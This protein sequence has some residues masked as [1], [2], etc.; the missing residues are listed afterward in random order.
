[1]VKPNNATSSEQEW[2]IQVQHQLP[3]SMVL[4]VGYVGAAG[5]HLIDKYNL[6]EQLF[7]RPAGVH[8]YPGL[9]SVDVQDARG[10]S[11]YHALQTE[12]SRR[13]SNGLQ[14]TAAYTFSKTIDDGAGTNGVTGEQIF[15][16]IRLDRS[17]ADIDLRNRFVLSGVY[18]LPFGRGKK[19]GG[20]ISKAANTLVGGW[21]LNTIIT[22]QSGIPFSLTT[23]GQPSSG[24]PTDGRPDL[25]G[26]LT[27]NP[28]NTYQY[29]NIKAV[30]QAPQNGDGVLLRQ[31]TLGRN[32]LIGP[33]A[34]TVDL[35]MF[36]N[37]ALT[38]RFKLEFRAEAFNIA[39]HPVYKQPNTDITAGNFGQITDTQIGSERQL[40]G[41]L[42]LFF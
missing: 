23:P 4:S 3:Y 5:H 2:N 15:Q 40:Q 17:L 37:F 14:F 18:E 32:V 33:G 11:I 26:N 19:F 6:N 20:N 28:G 12:L 31:G 13:F 7:N 21:Q 10:N 38:E 25:V 34:R 24:S 9:G 22:I 8:L 16:S 29:F 41:V 36:K 35:S 30:A 39:N 1:V 27:T 42:R